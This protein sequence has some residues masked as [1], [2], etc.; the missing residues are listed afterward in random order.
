V[1]YTRPRPPLITLSGRTYRVVRHAN[2]RVVLTQV[3][4]SMWRL[5]PDRVA[6]CVLAGLGVVVVAG[7]MR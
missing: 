3:S 6:A 4:A 2:A 1:D 5:A 7:G